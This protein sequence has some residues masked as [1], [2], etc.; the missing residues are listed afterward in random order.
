MRFTMLK[1]QHLSLNTDLAACWSLLHGP[2]SGR[3]CRVGAALSGHACS[4]SE[5]APVE[6]RV[7]GALGE[8]QH[9]DN[10]AD[11]VAGQLLVNAAQVDCTLIPEVQL[12]QGPW[13]LPWLLHSCKQGAITWKL[14][15]RRA[16]N[17]RGSQRKCLSQH[18]S[19][20]RLLCT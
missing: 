19:L 16:V 2:T 6:G 9:L 13:K 8:L 15:Q 1:M 3:Q 20:G 10:L 12:L 14:L 11:A 5:C 7:V 4:S 17:Q 18:G